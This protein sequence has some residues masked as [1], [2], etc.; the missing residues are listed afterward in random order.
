M[1]PLKELVRSGQDRNMTSCERRVNCQCA[2]RKSGAAE[3]Y[4]ADREDSPGIHSPRQV[5]NI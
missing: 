3:Y 4:A 5:Q 1:P 2:R